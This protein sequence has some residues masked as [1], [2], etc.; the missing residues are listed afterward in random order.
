MIS[1]VMKKLL[2]TTLIVT[3]ILGMGSV[4]HAQTQTSGSSVGSGAAA[5][6]IGLGTIGQ[7]VVGAAVGPVGK[8]GLDV[9]GSV[10]TNY[11]TGV[12]KD[13]IY[14][15]IANFFNLIL[16][17]TAWLV[18]ISGT[19]LNLSL[20]I[21][22]HVKDLYDSAQGLNAVWLTVRDLSSMLIIFALLYY[23]ILTIVGQ[24]GRKVNEFIAMIFIAGIFINFSLFFARVG[25]D[26]SNLVSLHI[27]NA[28]APNSADNLT[29]SKAF[30]SGGIA[31][32][33]MNSL[34][35]PALYNSK[36]LSAGDILGGI[37][38]A[39]LGGIILMLTTAFSFLAAAIAFT[40]R[41]G[42]L[43]FCMALSPLYFAGLVFPKIKTKVSDKIMDVFTGQLLFMP[44]YLFLIYVALRLI[45]DPKFQE[46]FSPSVSPTY[47][48][49]IF[50][51][52][53]I[54][55]IVQYTIAIIFI[56]APLV[57]AI[58]MSGTGGFGM[59][60][61]PQADKIAGVFSSFAGRNVLGRPAEKLNKTLSNTWLGNTAIGRSARASTLG[62]VT[63]SKFGG[64]TS[65]DDA[66]KLE[67]EIKK[68]KREMDRLAE[69]EGAIAAKNSAGIKD[70]LGKMTDNE[71]ANLD[72]KILTNSMVVP[73][74]SSNVYRNVDKSEMKDEDKIAIAKARVEAID[75]IGGDD[76]LTPDEKS[77]KIKTIVKNMSG[78]DLEAYF[79]AVDAKEIEKKD[80]VIAHLTQNQLKE[81]E[82]LDPEKR[83]II[84][85]KIMSWSKT[86]GRHHAGQPHIE[87]NKAAWGQEDGGSGSGSGG[88]PV[89]P[90]SDSPPSGKKFTKSYG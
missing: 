68:K 82:S 87:K 6:G 49:V 20:N 42:I 81:M 75:K 48:G 67:K 85:D 43:L 57:T 69:L 74:L 3:M 7:A 11:V 13:T 86:H 66:A 63:A 51:P 44:V 31:N 88:G 80:D 41:T 50:G 8:I 62:A 56:N 39:T 34:R 90:P 78:E 72:K 18:A 12:S 26:A 19:F 36:V 60:W 28:I 76:K 30:D 89:I 59:K 27:Y 33:F 14:S 38:S 4:A 79:E 77:T 61:A 10:A 70:A 54:G 1:K 53:T 83:K 73:Y 32:V 23:S 40:A 71:I 16:Q 65:R 21:T 25:V 35:L 22:T 2:T 15:A 29:V 24:G 47:S 45:S 84:G 58:S 9:A 46:V 37:V 64:S 52:M 17:F 5:G 55:V